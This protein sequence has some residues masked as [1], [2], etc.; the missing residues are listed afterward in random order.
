MLNNCRLE[1]RIVN[2]RKVE[3]FVDSKGTSVLPERL[4][5]KRDKGRSLSE[6]PVD[7]FAVVIYYIVSKRIPGE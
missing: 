5:T 6:Q 4:R 3:N 2:P 7:K 1:Q